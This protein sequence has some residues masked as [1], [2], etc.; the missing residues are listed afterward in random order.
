M[1]D[2]TLLDQCIEGDER[3]WREFLERYRAIIYGSILKTLGVRG[4]SHELADDVF[5]DVLLKLLSNDCRALK[6][7]QRRSKTTTWLARVAINATIDAVRRRRARHE[8]SDLPGGDT[9]SDNSAEEILKRIPVDA[10]ILEGVSSRDMADRLL[11]QLEEQDH[12]ILRMYFFGGLKEREIA[13]LLGI[14]INTLSS[15]KSRALEKLKSAARE[16]L[17]VSS[18]GLGNESERGSRIDEESS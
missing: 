11:G 8:I 6:R 4:E 16:L 13:E 17:R 12:L 3:A 2:N 10:R 9:E 1:D 15:R 18:D 14:P 5:Q 7:F